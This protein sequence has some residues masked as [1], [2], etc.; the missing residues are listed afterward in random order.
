VYVSSACTVVAPA[1]EAVAA[2][3]ARAQEI[4]QRNMAIIDHSVAFWKGRSGTAPYTADELTGAIEFFETLTRIKGA[5]LSFIGPIP[6]E[7]LEKLSSEWK[8]WRAKQGDRLTY[9]TSKRRV[10]VSD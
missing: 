7:S 2:A 4:W 8:I 5:N 3:R 1:P 10:V 9:D 6:D